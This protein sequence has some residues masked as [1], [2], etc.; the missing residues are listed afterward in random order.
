MFDQTDLFRSPDSLEE[1]EFVLVGQTA[2]VLVKETRGAS[3]G[4]LWAAKSC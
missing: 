2:L 4:S 3:W 1:A